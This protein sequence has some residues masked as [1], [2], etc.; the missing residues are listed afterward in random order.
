MKKIPVVIVHEN[1]EKYLKINLDITTKNNHVYLIGNKEIANLESENVTFVDI[2]KY[3]NL[4]QINIMKENFRNYGA[5]DDRTELFWFSRVIMISE[6]MKEY[7]V[8]KIFNIDSDNI[9]LDDVN[10]YPYSHEN[11]LCISKNWHENYLTA[12]IHCGLINENFCK[13]YEKLYFDI[14]INKSKFKLIEN[15][16]SFHKNRPGGI[17]DMTLYYL[18][19]SENIINIHNL[20][21]PVLVDGVKSVFMNNVSNSEGYEYQDQYSIKNKYIKITKKKDKNFLYD[22]YNKEYLNILNIHFQG[23]AKKKMNKLLKYKLAL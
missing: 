15:K 1:Y 16:V 8:E 18:L 5:K 2:S 10:K 17:A 22:K 7:E 4:S 12:S 23:K 13:E 11:A 9:L 6:F 21:E 20:L 14:F 19:Y 3:K